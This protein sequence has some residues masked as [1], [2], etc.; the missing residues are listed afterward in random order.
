MTL[1]KDIK[2][3][4]ASDS[5][6]DKDKTIKK[7]KRKTKETPDPPGRVDITPYSGPIFDSI[8]Y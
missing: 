2:K 7:K 5:P 3:R 6:R 8:L 4:T 1:G